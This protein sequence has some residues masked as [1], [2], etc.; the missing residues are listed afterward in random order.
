MFL[1]DFKRFRRK[2]L[3]N[4]RGML[5]NSNPR[6]KDERSAERRKTRPK[7]REDAWDNELFKH[8]GEAEKFNQFRSSGKKF[9]S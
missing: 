2:P 9:S 3:D 6:P 5:Y 4:Q 7:E 1:K 8:H